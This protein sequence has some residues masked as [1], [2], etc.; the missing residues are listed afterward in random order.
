MFTLV[1]TA[2]VILIAM[3]NVSAQTTHPWA[4]PGS[5]QLTENRGFYAIA[6]LDLATG[7]SDVNI[8]YS[9]RFAGVTAIGGYRIT[10]VIWTGIGTG[11]LQFNGGSMLPLFF[12]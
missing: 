10:P 2:M 9:E 11:V 7:L 5:P 12:D 4:S 3:N 8:P 6:G 1:T